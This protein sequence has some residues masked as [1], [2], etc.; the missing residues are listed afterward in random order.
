MCYAVAITAFV[1]CFQ[2]GF[3]GWVSCSSAE[4]SACEAVAGLISSNSKVICLMLCRESFL[5]GS[6]AGV[7]TA[8]SEAAYGPDNVGKYDPILHK[9]I[10]QPDQEKWA[11]R[12]RA[13]VSQVGIIVELFHLRLRRAGHQLG[14]HMWELMSWS[15]LQGTC[16]VGTPP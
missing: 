5:P 12:E 11:A 3:A 4:V 7:H 13:H 9:W 10:V 14:M 2:A 15:M 16:S 1:A 8:Q 6:K